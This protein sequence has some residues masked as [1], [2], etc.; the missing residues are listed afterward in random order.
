M[1]TLRS[2]NVLSCAKVAGALYGALG[3]VLL[4]FFA[5]ASFASFFRS[6]EPFSSFATFV[7]AILCPVFYGAIGFLMGAFTA[8]IYNLSANW[9][10]GLRLEIEVDVPAA[11]G[12]SL[13]Q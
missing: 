1:Y 9:V 8:W 2:V 5:L 12:T 3:L 11:T 4:P 7:V 6:G 10:G 13:K